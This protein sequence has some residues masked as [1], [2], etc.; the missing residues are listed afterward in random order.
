[1]MATRQFKPCYASTPSKE[2]EDLLEESFTAHATLLT[3]TSAFGLG[4]RS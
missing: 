1:M 3:A 2:L 4:R